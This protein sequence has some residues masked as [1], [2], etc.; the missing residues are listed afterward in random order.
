MDVV[1]EIRMQKTSLVALIGILAFFSSGT[2]L[3]NDYDF[4]SVSF[5]R[6]KED[7]ENIKNFIGN[8]DIKIIAKIENLMA[9]LFYFV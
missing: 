6:T 4:L 8:A 9:G 3:D 2:A 5:V 1:G 7:I